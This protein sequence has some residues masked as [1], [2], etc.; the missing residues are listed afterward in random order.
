MLKTKAMTALAVIPL[1]LHS[2]WAHPSGAENTD[3]AT[4]VNSR[5]GILEERDDG[6][7]EFHETFEIPHEPGVTIGWGLQLAS[8][9]EEVTYTQTCLQPGSEGRAG[10]TLTETDTSKTANGWIAGDWSIEADDPPGKHRIQVAIGDEI[11]KEFEYF[12]RPSRPPVTSPQPALGPQPDSRAQTKSREYSVAIESHASV[13]YTDSASTG[14]LT[15]ELLASIERVGSNHP[16][17]VACALYSDT[18][19][20]FVA[21]ASLLHQCKT[22]ECRRMA[23]DEFMDAHLPYISASYQI[24]NYA[25]AYEAGSLNVPSSLEGYWWDLSRQLLEPR[26]KAYLE[27]LTKHYQE[28]SAANATAREPPRSS[29]RVHYTSG[30]GRPNPTRIPGVSY[31]TEYSGGKIFQIGDAN[32]LEV[33]THL[34]SWSS[35]G[36]RNTAFVLVRTGTD[37]SIH[38]VPA[39]QISLTVTS[40][41]GSQMNVMTISAEDWAAHERKKAVWRSIGAAVLVGLANSGPTGTFNGRYSNGYNTW[42]FSGEYTDYATRM[43]N[44]QAQSAAL[45]GR[46]ASALENN[47]MGLLWPETLSPGEE[48]GGLVNFRKWGKRFQKGTLTVSVGDQIFTF[49]WNPPS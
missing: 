44:I 37:S 9:A 49:V 41:D 8:V 20:R 23:F 5:F 14:P 45:G 32:G 42:S 7:I 16:V 35:T 19:S 17:A 26:H 25:R 47:T 33:W 15:E 40:T 30:D 38:F 27:A 2:T 12:L 6:S 29:S 31:R 28:Y 13:A 21:K 39:N 18:S 36:S 34:I 1:L 48:V 22:D 43:M 11:V 10:Q 4:V 3:R 24:L 46:I